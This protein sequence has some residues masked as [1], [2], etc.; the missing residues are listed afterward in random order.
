MTAAVATEPLKSPPQR[1]PAVVHIPTNAVADIWPLVAGWV[2]QVCDR[3]DQDPAAVLARCRDG[4]AQLWCVQSPA[5]L[6]AMVVTEI[7]QRPSGNVLNIWQCA[8]S[9]RKAWVQAVLAALE[10][11]ARAHDCVRMEITG[12]LGWAADLPEWRR[13]A[14]VF[15]K[16]L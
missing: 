7:Q 3:A 5:G 16:E 6:V 12:R 4:R 11:F 14:I 9:G 8:G 10:S 2:G 15:T 1:S 13:A